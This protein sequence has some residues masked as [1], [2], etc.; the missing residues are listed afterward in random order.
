VSLA[1]DILAA[2]K[3]PARRVVVLISESR[4]R[5]SKAHFQDVAAKAEKDDVVI[6]TLSYS[7]YTTAFTQKASERKVADEP[8]LYDPDDKGG[9]SFPAIAVELARL[10]KINVSQALA[11]ATGGAHEKFTTLSGLETQLAAIGN[12]IHTR[13]TL[14]FVPPADQPAG[15]HQLSVSVKSGDSRIHARAGYWTDAQTTP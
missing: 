1:C 5:G 2:R 8:G 4:D 3:E 15:Y 14:T 11:E 7:A 6:Y 13:Y 9:I 10:A 12:E